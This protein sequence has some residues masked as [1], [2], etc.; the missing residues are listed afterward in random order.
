MRRPAAESRAKPPRGVAGGRRLACAERVAEEQVVACAPDAEQAGA[1][2]V[3]SEEVGILDEP[4]T[5][6]I[7]CPPEQER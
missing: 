4:E 3:V 6:V 2:R 1:D 7:G 5:G